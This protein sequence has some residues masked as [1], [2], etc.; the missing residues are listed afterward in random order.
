[1]TEP[2]RPAVALPD[3]SRLVALIVGAFALASIMA[4][5]TT[6]PNWGKTA[7][8][9]TGVAAPTAPPQ[10]SRSTETPLRSDAVAIALGGPGQR[11]ATDYLVRLNAGDAIAYSWTA[12]GQ[13]SFELHGH[14]V[15]AADV[16]GDQLTYF[17]TGTAASGNG[18]FIAPANGFYGWYFQPRTG[19]VEISL[20]LS[21][22]YLP[23]PGLYA[24]P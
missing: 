12:T 7:N 4:A 15:T 3:R 10:V 20:Q 22:F 2:V 14:D 9:D 6:V 18:Y 11:A 1:M 13:V 8:P 21:G 5:V 24:V 17:A 19:S 16:L 23:Q